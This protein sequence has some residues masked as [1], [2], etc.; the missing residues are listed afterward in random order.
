MKTYTYVFC[1]NYTKYSEECKS[2]KEAVDK[3][4]WDIKYGKHFPIFIL[5]D[6]KIVKTQMDIANLYRERRKKI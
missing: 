4:L 5:D 2:L 1:A 6:D 3:A